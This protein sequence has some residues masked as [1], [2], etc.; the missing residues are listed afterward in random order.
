MK[1]RESGNMAN[2]MEEVEELGKQMEQ[3]SDQAEE[4]REEGLQQD[5]AQ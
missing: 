2:D 4:A 1:E 3:V 5:P